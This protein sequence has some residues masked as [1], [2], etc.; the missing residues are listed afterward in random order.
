MRY[1][2]TI[3]THDRTFATTQGSTDG[4]RGDSQ[5]E[6]GGEPVARVLVSGVSKREAAARAY[7][8]CVGR[9]RARLLRERQTTRRVA[10]QQ[11]NARAIAAS[12]RKLN[13]SGGDCYL[14]DDLVEGW[15]V[16]VEPVVDLPRPSPRRLRLP[17]NTLV[18]LCRT[19]S[20]N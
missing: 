18:R 7:V 17:H 11:T 16:H 1:F 4:G 5:T 9:D 14:M 8:E 15:F 13:R 20:L 19:P 12:L 10:K 3:Y 6:G 2:C